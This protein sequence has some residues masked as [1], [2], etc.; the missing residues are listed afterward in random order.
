MKKLAAAADAKFSSPTMPKSIRLFRSTVP[1]PDSGV[2]LMIEYEDMA[3]YGARTVFEHANAEW[4]AL[5]EPARDAPE[6]LV[7]VELLTEISP[8]DED[9]DAAGRLPFGFRPR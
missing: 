3:A 4:R 2:M 7:S 6:N 8:N 1:G 9:H 5:F